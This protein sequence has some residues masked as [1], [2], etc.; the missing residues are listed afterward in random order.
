MP[1]DKTLRVLYL[2]GC[3]EGPSKR[4]R[5]FNHIEALG[6]YGVQSEW[7]WD[8]DE[9]I[10]NLDYLRQFSIVVVFRSGFNDRVN[11]LFNNIKKLDIPLV[12]DID[13]LVFDPDLVGHVDAYR[14]MDEAGQA[15]YLDG[16]K[17]IRRALMLCPYI[18]TSTNFLADKL[19]E[20]FNKPTYVVP[21]G[22]NLRQ[23]KISEI[24]ASDFHDAKF[25]GYLSG[26]SSHQADFAQAAPALRRILE[27]YDDVF[28]KVV[29]FLDVSTY[30]AG[31]EHKVCRVDFM[32]WQYLM[33]E[34]A[35]CL[36]NIAP[37]EVDS[38]FCKAKS[39]LKFVE[40]AL[41]GVPIVASA[42]PAFCDAI[43]NG[44]NGF[45]AHNDDEWYD[46]LASVIED[47]ALRNRVAAE[48]KLTIARTY[49]PQRIGARLV[50]IYT[51]IVK[52][53][54]GKQ[55]I[56]ETSARLPAVPVSFRHKEKGLR[57]SWVIPQPFEASGGH[58]N[59]FRAIKYLSEF[60]HTCTL[61]ILPDNHRF[62]TGEEA[63]EFIKREFFDIKT[64]KVVWGVDEIEESDVLVCT[65]WT[66]AYVID[67]VKSR[68]RLH[69]YFLQ[70]FEPMFFPMG[71]DYVRALETY[72]L[73]FYH[74]TSGPWPLE[75]L[76]N[77][78]G[79]DRGSFFRFPLDRGIYYPAV[80]D[81][82]QST[83]DQ[84][85]DR[86]AFFARPDMPRRCYTLGVMALEIV[87]QLRP[88]VEI[89]FY[90]DKKEKYNNVPFSFV[91]LGMTDTIFELGDLYRS[92]TL[93]VCFSTTN[94]SLVPFEMMA[95]GCP[96]VDLNVN[97][98]HVNYGGEDNSVLV[99]PNP[100]AIADGIIRILDDKALAATLAER[101]IAFAS[102]FPTEVEMA[103]LIEKVILDQYQI[104][105][106]NALAAPE[107]RAV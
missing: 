44:V 72:R 47:D 57:I 55:N 7:I 17:S 28:L 56:T 71:V 66:T 6:L 14:R 60:G 20:N 83:S 105:Q 35:T 104:A 5:V 30:L 88:Q 70:D 23:L 69:L 84:S 8:I 62:S 82:D 87:K 85:I 94:P 9:K 51:E 34:T 74:L 52:S 65:Y 59:I 53:H 45:I 99:S 96:V 1:S 81:A 54:H 77:T 98:N 18:T 25:I 11:T 12:Y 26:T 80:V 95:C 58:R 49:Y 91:N 10:H 38:E 22:V 21:F 46:A 29:G 106:E 16:M 102:H 73:G 15:S 33:I 63:Y 75:M 41:S 48:A 86:I 39:E 4:Y 64:D 2:L 100:K 90:G 97:N 103:Q 32:D 3:N 19:I 89:V 92:A 43:K 13:D 37:F 76:K 31:L 42:V 107:V 27:K 61:H 79:I 24:V 78:L 101:G 50:E 36:V 93:G 68:A 40:A 67:A